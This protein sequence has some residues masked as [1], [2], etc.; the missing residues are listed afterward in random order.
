MNTCALFA[1]QITMY[2]N[3]EKPISCSS[4]KSHSPPLELT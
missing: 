4:P 1:K 2:N 3:S